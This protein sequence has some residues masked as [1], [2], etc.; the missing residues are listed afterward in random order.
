MFKFMNNKYNLNK[1]K[2]VKELYIIIIIIINICF[3]DIKY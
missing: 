2:F 1:S 3:V